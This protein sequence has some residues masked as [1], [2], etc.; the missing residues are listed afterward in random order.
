MAYI[1][2]LVD[3]E[4]VVSA[5]LEALLAEYGQTN[6]VDFEIHKFGSTKEFLDSGTKRYDIIFLDI[7]LPNDINGLET[8]K[9]L[10]AEYS[11][12]IIIF[13]TSY[14]QYAVNGYEVGALSYII[15]PVEKDSFI[16]SMNRA[17]NVLKHRV[18]H[19]MLVRTVDGQELINISE[20]M[21]VE[22]MVHNLF[23]HVKK[24]D[25]VGVVRTRGSLNE[26]ADRLSN[27]NFARCSSC[28]L[29]NLA[30]VTGVGKKYVQ[31]SDGNTLTIS[32]KFSKDFTNKFMR[33]IAEFGVIDG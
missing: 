4:S 29:I 11:K 12:A 32:R 21:Y 26:I 30:H 6:G 25:E 14:A 9:M 16:N 31:L 28:Y 13:C 5:Q 3:D 19:K 7:N 22:V 8:A 23:F 27:L 17:V 10:R 24:G 33:Y 2:A 18:E 20:L 15:K 1:V